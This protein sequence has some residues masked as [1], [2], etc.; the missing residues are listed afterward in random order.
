M[1]F[2]GEGGARTRILDQHD[3]RLVSSRQR[4]RQLAQLRIVISAPRE[5]EQIIDFVVHQ[6]GC[7]N[8]PVIVCAVFSRGVPA[9]DKRGLMVTR[10]K[11][12]PGVVAQPFA[13]DHRAAHRNGGLL[14]LRRELV[15]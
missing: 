2:L 13:L 9:L 10:G 7:A 14:I 1:E 3:V 15:G 5:F 6:P 8:R 12:I 4:N 11:L